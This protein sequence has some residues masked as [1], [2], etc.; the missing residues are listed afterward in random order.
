MPHTHD[1]KE[2]LARAIKQRLERLSAKDKSME[3]RVLS[4]R[5]LELV[6]PPPANICAFVPLIDEVAIHP[7]LRTLLQDGYTLYLP[8]FE[9][10][11]VFRQATN[12]DTLKPGKFGIPEPSSAAP[13]LDEKA[14]VIALV[15]GRAFTRSGDRMGRGNGGYD[16]WI[17]KKRAMSPLSQFWGVCHECQI[18]DSVP[19]EAHDEK[20]DRVI[21]ARGSMGER[22]D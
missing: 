15:P 18:V 11:L 2:A 8:V 21:T 14:E 9:G 22:V 5:I 3:G 17:R 12:L 19:M 6:P 16:I 7:L 1:E 20:V 13:M 10:S 4:K